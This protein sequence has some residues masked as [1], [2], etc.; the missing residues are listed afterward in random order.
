MPGRTYDKDL[1]VERLNEIFGNESQIVTASRLNTSQ[2]NVSK[3]KSGEAKPTID[4]L[5]DISIVYDVSID[6]LMGI[7]DNKR[8]TDIN[9]EALTY[10]QVMKVLDRLL[11]YDCLIIPNLYDICENCLD[12]ESMDAYELESKNES[13]KTEKYSAD[14][15]QCNDRILS[16]FL[17]KRRRCIDVD[18]DTYD[19][20]GQKNHRIFN[21][22]SIVDCRGNIN[23]ALYLTPNSSALDTNGWKDRIDELRAITEKDLQ[24][25]INSKEEGQYN[26]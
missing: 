22:T 24:T 11:E 8:T 3:W 7:S 10:E 1:S 14:V 5:L 2:G 13:E 15:M 19:T 17:E 9:I 26:G 4:Y 12:Q 16:Y 25:L 18:K 23:K 6:W 20:W 21:E